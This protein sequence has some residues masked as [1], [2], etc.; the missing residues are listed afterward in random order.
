MLWYPLNKKKKIFQWFLLTSLSY[1]DL[2]IIFQMEMTPDM[3]RIRSNS[4]L[5][6]IKAQTFTIYLLMSLM[7]V[8]RE[9]SIKDFLTLDR[10][11]V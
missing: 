8:I 10:T 4:F 3:I 2:D 1:L 6:M 9:K 11:I 5:V 7:I